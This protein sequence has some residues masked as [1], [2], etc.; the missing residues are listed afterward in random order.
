MNKN[1]GKFTKNGLTCLNQENR[2]IEDL[3]SYPRGSVRFLTLVIN[4]ENPVHIE[5]VLTF[6]NPQYRYFKGNEDL[7]EIISKADPSIN[8]LVV[9]QKVGRLLSMMVENP[10]NLESQ[11]TENRSVS[12]DKTV[13]TEFDEPQPSLHRVEMENTRGLYWKY[14]YDTLDHLS[15][16]LT[17]RSLT[18]PVSEKGNRRLQEKIN[19]LYA[20]KLDITFV[21]DEQNKR[22]AYIDKHL[23]NLP[24]GRRGSFEYML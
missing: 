5:Y 11:S 12:A 23:S 6:F 9:D 7:F 14:L 13:V 20:D 8:I 21:N 10:T 4:A 3:Q 24:S 15:S 22:K 16:K 2:L 17:D 1:S 19:R 18:W